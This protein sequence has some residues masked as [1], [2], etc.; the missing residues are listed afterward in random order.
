LLLLADKP[1][2][3]LDAQT[4]RDVLAMLRA[5]RACAPLV[6]LMVTTRV[7]GT[8]SRAD[9]HVRPL[10]PNTLATEKAP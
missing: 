2:R 10:K 7:K 1:T 3:V 8:V 6:I 9:T 5:I 4:A